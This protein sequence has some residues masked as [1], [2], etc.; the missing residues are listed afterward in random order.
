[1]SEQ[2]PEREIRP[3]ARPR[4]VAWLPDS[5][6]RYLATAI[7]SSP[8]TRASEDPAG[9]SALV[10][11]TIVQDTVLGCIWVAGTNGVPAKFT[12]LALALST[13]LATASTWAAVQT[14]PDVD[15]I[16]VDPVAPTKRGRLDA[17]NVTA[18][19]TRI[20]YLPDQDLDLA[21]VVAELAAI[22]AENTDVVVGMDLAQRVDVSG[23]W[24]L[25]R[26]GAAVYVLTRTAGAATEAVAFR[27]T[28]LR[29]RTTAS[30]G[31]KITGCR[32]KYKVETA[33]LNDLTVSGAFSIMP[34]T[35]AAVA[36]ATSL[37]TVTYDAAHD[38]TGERKAIGEHTLTATFGTPVYLS[39]G[40]VELLVTV[41]AALTSALTINKVELLCAETIVD[42]A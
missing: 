24:T 11:G 7:D 39:E 35:G 4:F 10:P 29:Q 8:D 20:L 2:R 28:T 1:M 41:D 42:A 32:I 27:A 19:Q 26:V 40:E 37:G 9:L 33:D 13:I 14:F 38:T 21:A 6:G 36:A 3:I 12:S 23:V 25:T 15:L 31:L 30:K 5:Q 34:A 17:G 18:G 22:V 16:V